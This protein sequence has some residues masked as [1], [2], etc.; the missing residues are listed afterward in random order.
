MPFADAP[1][2]SDPSSIARSAMIVAWVLP[3]VLAAF[4][5]AAI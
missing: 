5:F 4:F 2:F 1:P 3:Y